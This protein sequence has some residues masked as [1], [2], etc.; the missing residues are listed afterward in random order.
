MLVLYVEEIKINNV[1]TEKQLVNLFWLIPCTLCLTGSIDLSEFL[2]I[3][4]PMVFPK[5]VDLPVIPDNS[6]MESKL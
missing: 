1:I 4:N 3:R 6:T 2:S 5:L